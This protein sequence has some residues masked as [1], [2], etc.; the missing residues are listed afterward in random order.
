MKFTAMQNG[1]I[2]KA[3]DTYAEAEK[4]FGSDSN[5]IPIISLK[6]WANMHKDYKTVIDGKPHVVYYGKNG[7]ALGPCEIVYGYPYSPA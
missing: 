5:I 2:T 7:T 4:Y 3:F 1:V 6:D